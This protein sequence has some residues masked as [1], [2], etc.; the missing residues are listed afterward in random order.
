M[1]QQHKLNSRLWRC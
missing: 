1:W